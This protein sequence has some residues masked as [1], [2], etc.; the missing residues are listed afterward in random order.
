M[1]TEKQ[2]QLGLLVG[3]LCSLIAVLVFRVAYYDGISRMGLLVTGSLL[4]LLGGVFSKF[5]AKEKRRK[6]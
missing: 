6:F 5:D 3:L 2:S 1:V 4:G